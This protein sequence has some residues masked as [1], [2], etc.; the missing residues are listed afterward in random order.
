MSEM[1]LLNK[2][3]QESALVRDN[4]HKTKDALSRFKDRFWNHPV[5][6]MMFYMNIFYLPTLKQV[7]GQYRIWN[8][9]VFWFTQFMN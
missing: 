5:M 1:S 3:D 6:L 2:T 8:E 7:V 4:F 9:I